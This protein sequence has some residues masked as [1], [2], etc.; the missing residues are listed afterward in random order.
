MI[1]KIL[2]KEKE[3]E[4]HYTLELMALVPGIFDLCADIFGDEVEFI[5]FGHQ[6]LFMR[7]VYFGV[8]KKAGKKTLNHHLASCEYKYS[9]EGIDYH[10]ASLPQ[11]HPIE[12]L[13]LKCT[14]SLWNLLGKVYKK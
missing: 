14:D 10:I 4:A 11:A 2:A 12:M 1:N 3:I 13:R 8:K 6:E 5:M 7:K 9:H